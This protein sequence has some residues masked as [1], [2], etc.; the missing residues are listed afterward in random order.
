MGRMGG[1]GSHSHICVSKEGLLSWDPT[2]AITACSAP[3][4]PT[5]IHSSC[6]QACLCAVCTSAVTYKDCVRVACLLW[7]HTLKYIFLLNIMFVRFIHD[8]ICVV[9]SFIYLFS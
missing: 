5:L 9:H 8:D 7:H 1:Y 2:R 6:S 4:A 3:G